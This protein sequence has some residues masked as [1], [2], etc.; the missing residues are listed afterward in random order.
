MQEILFLTLRRLAVLT[1]L[2]AVC[3]LMLP[4]GRMRQYARLAGGLMTT[5]CILEPVLGAL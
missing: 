4:S 2:L 5:L 1:M 3:D